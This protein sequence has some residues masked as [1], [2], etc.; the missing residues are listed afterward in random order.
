MLI[1]CQMTYAQRTIKGT[2]TDAETGEPL[3]GAYVLVK[4]GPGTATEFDGSFEITVPE[5]AQ[6]LTIS[7]TGYQDQVID[8]T[9][10]P[11]NVIDVALSPGETLEEV[12]VIGYGTVK[13]EDATGSI[14]TVNSES[15]NKGAITAPQDLL[16]GKVAGVQITRG[17]GAP[18]EGSVIRIRGGSSLM[19]SN[20]P[21]IVV[22]GVP[23]DNGGV[24]GA[25]N[26][27]NLINP[28][29]IETFT[30]LKDASA[31]AIYGSRASNGVILITTK[32]GHLGR[33]I[34]VNYTGNVS[35]SSAIN[36]VDIFSADE[37][38]ALINERFP[39]GHPARDLVGTESTYW[40][41]VVFETGVGTDHNLSL[42]GGI[43]DLVPYRV[44]L[45]YSDQKGILMTDRFQRTTAAL[46]LSPGLLDNQLQINVNVKGMNTDN[47]FA[48]R[49]AIGG[50]L[51]FDPTKPVYDET[52]PFGGFWS[53]VLF[54]SLNNEY[55]PVGLSPANPLSLL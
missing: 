29:D 16:A 31:T 27:L 7:Y 50:A 18:G 35:F 3:I 2:V 20:D 37:F 45:G 9:Q 26:I 54:D 46:N 52:N 39:D 41:D 55:R 44:S 40:P 21:L 6:T 8:L 17:S 49:G 11:S 5:S 30:V 25:R 13:K 51:S 47:T 48:D 23:L 24:A 33:A 19:A 12:V 43:A 34:Q 28:N 32:K 36:Q 42:S 15:F 22:D 10:N 38:R 4:D 14:Q 53:W 1:F